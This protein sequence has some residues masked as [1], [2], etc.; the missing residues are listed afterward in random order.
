MTVATP[1]G[2]AT[3][4]LTLENVLYAPAVG[5]TLISLGALDVLGYQMGIEAGHLE[6]T[7]PQGTT[8]ARV[9]RTARGL[10]RV[11]HEEGAHAVEVVSVI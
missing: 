11:T 6:I 2:S 7:S 4:S 5:Y 1:L 9:P 3:S 10:Y 8:V